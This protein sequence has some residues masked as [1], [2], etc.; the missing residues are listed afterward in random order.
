MFSPIFVLIPDCCSQVS[1]SLPWLYTISIRGPRIAWKQAKL[2]SFIKHSTICWGSSKNKD[3]KEMVT[4][5]NNK[6]LN[7]QNI[8]RHQAPQSGTQAQHWRHVTKKAIV[9]WRRQS[10]TQCSLLILAF[11]HQSTHTCGAKHTVKLMLFMEHDSRFQGLKNWTHVVY[12]RNSEFFSF[13][14]SITITGK[15]PKSTTDVMI[16][17]IRG[18]HDQRAFWSVET[19]A[20][21]RW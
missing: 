19:M 21:F 20:F 5:L 9:P 1:Y 18:R 12:L 7:S 10:T 16:K 6:K 4:K 11:I 17:N 2:E 13:A 3:K 8:N 14:L 15:A